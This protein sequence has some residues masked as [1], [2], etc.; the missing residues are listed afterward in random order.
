MPMKTETI[1]QYLSR[2]FV[3]AIGTNEAEAGDIYMF[4]VYVHFGAIKAIFPTISKAHKAAVAIKSYLDK[5]VDEK[6]VGSALSYDEEDVKLLFEYSKDIIHEIIEDI[7]N[8]DSYTVEQKWLEIWMAN[9]SSMFKVD[10]F[11]TAFLHVNKEA[12]LIADLNYKSLPHLSPSVILNYFIE[13]SKRS[14][15]RHK[16]MRIA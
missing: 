1:R 11:N 10:D 9:C 14:L 5:Q 12:Y 13:L 3:D 16:F 2:A 7:W 15:N 8:T 6:A 4:L